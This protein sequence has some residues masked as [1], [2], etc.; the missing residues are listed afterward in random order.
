MQSTCAEQS[1]GHGSV[2][3]GDGRWRRFGVG[4]GRMGVDWKK[5]KACGGKEPK[6][7]R[8]EEHGLGGLLVTAV[9]LV[10][11]RPLRSWTFSA[12]P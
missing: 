8:R 2:G 5:A 6:D 10:R 1:R 4:D 12:L 3:T 11:T 9:A 7:A